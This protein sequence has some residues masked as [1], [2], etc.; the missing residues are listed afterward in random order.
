M[1]KENA[2]KIRNKIIAG[3]TAAIA[4]LYE[5]AKK[6]GWELVISEKG[7]IRKIRPT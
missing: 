6:N 4:Q 5:D 1:T 7:K 3:V 2:K